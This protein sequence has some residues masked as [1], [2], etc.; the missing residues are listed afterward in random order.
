MSPLAQPRSGRLQTGASP[1]R[2]PLPA[3]LSARLTAHFPH[4]GGLRAYRVPH[5]HP[6]GSGPAVRGWPRRLQRSNVFG[7]CPGHIP[8]VQASAS[9]HS[10]FGLFFLNNGR[11][12]DSDALPV[13]STQ[14]PTALVLAVAVL[15]SQAGLPRLSKTGSLC[16]EGFAPWYYSRR[17][18][19]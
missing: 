17:T 6:D 10:T 16:P 12:S 5:L 4:S 7:L 13:P 9:Q 11:I 8:L 15:P 18:L 3:A 2:N 1:L 19:R 14:P